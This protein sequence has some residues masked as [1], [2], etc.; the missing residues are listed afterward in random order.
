MPSV[1]GLPLTGQI[2]STALRSPVAHVHVCFIEMATWIFR[3][4][5]LLEKATDSNITGFDK[6]HRNAPEPA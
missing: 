4:N 1:F 3:K 5:A 6:Q 2:V